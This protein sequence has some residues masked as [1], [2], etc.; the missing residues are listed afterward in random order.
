MRHSFAELDG[1]AL[2]L[3]P[4]FASNIP[5]YKMLGVKLNPLSIPELNRLI[6]TAIARNHRWII[7]NHNLH[8]V[9]LYH[10]SA[11]MRGFYAKADYTHVD[12]MPLVWLGRWLGFPLR[13][14][15]RVTYAD[16]TAPLMAEA[17]EQG[18]RIFYLGS[19][20]GVA[21]EAA[22]RLRQQFPGLQMV[23]TH[24]YFDPRFDSPENQAVLDQIARYK[25]HILMVGM[26][27][28]RQEY[29]I[30]DNLD[31]ISANTILTSGA[32]LDYV[33]GV[34]PT[35]PRWAGQLGLEWLFRLVA[36]PRRLAQRYLIEPWL[37]LRLF[38][39]DYIK[40]LMGVAKQT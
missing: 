22:H 16:W 28:P 13:R 2:D 12:G 10:R 20:P 39:I 30:Q 29:W 38:M 6:A 27:M 8:S 11:R 9:Y 15:Q 33:A 37:I 18:W 34:V 4:D 24:G 26:S 31:Q 21:E 19:K 1:Q 25:P 7:A 23:T 36:E 14:E 5:S 32:A 40:H 17:A 35:P 3:A